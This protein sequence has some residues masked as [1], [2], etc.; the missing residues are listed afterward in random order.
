MLNLVDQPHQLGVVLEKRVVCR[1]FS[2][3]GSSRLPRMTR[4]GLK[5]SVSEWLRPTALDVPPTAVPRTT[6]RKAVMDAHA[7]IPSRLRLHRNSFSFAAATLDE[8]DSHLMRDLHDDD[9]DDRSTPRVNGISKMSVDPYDSQSDFGGTARAISTP[10]PN[11]EETPAARLRALLQRVPGSATPK[12]TTR[13]RS[14]SLSGLESDLATDLD[15]SIGNANN[16]SDTPITPYSKHNYSP[17]PPGSVAHKSVK[18]IFSKAREELRTP[19]KPKRSR[20]S[21]IG[22]TPRGSPMPAA[23]SYSRSKRVSFSDDEV[24]KLTST[25]LKRLY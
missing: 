22:S 9:E 15:T 14:P 21:S 1:C 4:R 11:R 13:P 6:E 23:E 25:H 19:E 16:V 5:Q 3:Y 7:H 24:E 18:D 17:S 8:N 20:R 10:A 2:K 12:A